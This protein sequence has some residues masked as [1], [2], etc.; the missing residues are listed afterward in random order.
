MEIKVDVHKELLE[1]LN[2]AALENASEAD[3]RQEVSAIA[4]ETLSELGLAL[5]KDDRATLIQ[6]LMDDRMFPL[7]VSGLDDGIKSLH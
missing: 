7:T 4:A 1:S 6:E 3:L 2:L 5:N